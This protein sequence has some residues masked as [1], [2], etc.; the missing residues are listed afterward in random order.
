MFH[1]N[2]TLRG[3][4]HEV[5]LPDYHELHGGED[6]AGPPDFFGAETFKSGGVTDLDEFFQR[7]YQ[8]YCD[9]GFWCMFTKWL[10]ELVSLGFTIGFSGFLV[11]FV[12]WQ[13]LL[14][15]KCGIDAINEGNFHNCDLV[16]EALY[17]HPLTP[18]T[19]V[20]FFF[21][22]YLVLF[23]LYWLFCFLRFF[24]STARYS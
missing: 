6:S 22:T 2:E 10:C 18:F 13:G 5:E 21:V 3:V 12:N 19:L 1:K 7:V 16:K 8:Y 14:S 15:A 24:C 11:L 20:K 17:E 23:S 4:Q 9:K